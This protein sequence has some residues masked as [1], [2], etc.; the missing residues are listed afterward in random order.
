MQISQSRHLTPSWS[1]HLV[2]YLS[3]SLYM[4]PLRPYFDSLDHSLRYLRL[5]PWATKGWYHSLSYRVQLSGLLLLPLGI[6]WWGILS[7]GLTLV[8]AFDSHFWLRKW[9]IEK[10]WIEVYQTLILM[11]HS[12]KKVSF[13]NKVVIPQWWALWA[14]CRYIE[15]KDCSR[16]AWRAAREGSWVMEHHLNAPTLPPTQ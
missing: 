5:R 10:E 4:V 12:A 7:F 11:F 13:I 14:L 3:R 6:K 1:R 8:T 9:E 16:A 15:F 2:P